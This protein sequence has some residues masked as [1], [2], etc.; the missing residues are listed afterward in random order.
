MNDNLPII[1]DYNTII[2]GVLASF[3]TLSHKIGGELPKMANHVRGL[4]DAQQQFIHR[5][6]KS[7]KPIND[8]QIQE[9]IKPQSMEIE[10]ICGRE[11]LF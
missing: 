5:A 2:N 4:F 11:T 7:K 10:A 3:V 9:L 6:I 1:R 8:Q